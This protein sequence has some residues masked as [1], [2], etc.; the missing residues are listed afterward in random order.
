M[1]LGVACAAHKRTAEYSRGSFCWC[2]RPAS[3]GQYSDRVFIQKE[4]RSHRLA[5]DDECWRAAKSC[6]LNVEE[7][8]AGSTAVGLGTWTAARAARWR[9]VR[10]GPRDR[11]R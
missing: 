7:G 8:Q 11:R 5:H 3:I 4:A 10:L 6:G 2:F 9:T 1:V